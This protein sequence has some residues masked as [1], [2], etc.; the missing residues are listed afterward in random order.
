MFYSILIYYPFKKKKINI[1]FV[2]MFKGESSEEATIVKL[3]KPVKLHDFTY[4]RH[5]NIVFIPICYSPTTCVNNKCSRLILVSI[6]A[7][8]N[9]SWPLSNH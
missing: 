7:G 9:L 4:L 3:S 6:L 5:S 8:F 2:I 1:P